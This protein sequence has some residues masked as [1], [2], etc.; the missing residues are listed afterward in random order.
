MENTF[1]IRDDA[2]YTLNFLIYIQNIFLNQRSSE[3]ER[4]FPYIPSMHITFEEGFEFRYKELW[5]EVRQRIAENPF[6]DGKIFNGEKDLF[7]KRLFMD[8]N[9]S[10]KD[11]DEIYQSFKV[12]WGS[13]AGHFSVERSIGDVIENLYRELACT[14]IQRGITP[15]KELNISLV[16]DKCPL[17]NMEITS[18][19]AV[20]PINDFYVKYEELVTKL[21]KN[22]CN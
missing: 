17:G 11:Y 1:V 6:E 21:R 13:F 20:V 4:K 12:W 8:S 14:L 22:V 2:S 10:M 3:Q 16:Y 9:D 18:Y 15:K 5:D 7:F 19:F